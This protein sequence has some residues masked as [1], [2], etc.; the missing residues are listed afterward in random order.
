MKYFFVSDDSYFLSGLSSSL[1]EHNPEIKECAFFCNPVHDTNI[2]RPE[3]EDVVILYIFNV[4]IRR[5][6]MSRRELSSCHVIIMVKMKGRKWDDSL[7]NPMLISAELPYKAFIKSIKIL[8][9]GKIKEYHVSLKETEAFFYLGA[10]YSHPEVSELLGLT[11][12]SIYALRR[13]VNL[14][15][16]LGESNTAVSILLCRDIIEMQWHRRK[17][18]NEAHVSAQHPCRTNG[19]YCTGKYMQFRNNL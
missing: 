3:P 6:I 17:K 7:S 4:T 12:K 2:L 16:G 1:G 5:K 15:L 14:Q 18:C 9:L 19:R 11:T 13:Y 10:G 8:R